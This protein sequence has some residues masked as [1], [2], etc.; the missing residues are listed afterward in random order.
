MVKGKY[1]YKYDNCHQKLDNKL[2]LKYHITKEH[3][4]CDTCFTIFPTITSLNI[5]ITAALYY[6][7]IGLDKE[8]YILSINVFK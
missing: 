4:T 6:F 1:I 7:I 5:H 2:K 8:W 3:I